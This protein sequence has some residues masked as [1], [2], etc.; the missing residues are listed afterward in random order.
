VLVPLTLEVLR[1]TFAIPV[2]MPISA[3]ALIVLTTILAPLGAGVLIHAVAPRL[4]RSMAR[5]VSLFATVLL[6]LSALPVLV[7]AL[8]PT[9]ALVGNGSILA[10]LAFVTA[11]LVAGHLIG[12]P[13]SGERM[14][15]ALSTA[16]RHPGVALAIA[17]ASF[18]QQTLAM[19]AVLLY[20]LVGAVASAVYLK[21]FGS[22]YS[23]G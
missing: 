17:H 9:W 23:L 21:W 8:P 18:P 13:D 19:A 20:L 22:R 2:G 6:I 5:P 3:V 4:A 1:R 14:V 12:G 16:S 15:L 7:A 10:L 11:G